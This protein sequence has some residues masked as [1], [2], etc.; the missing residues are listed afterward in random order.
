MFGF[1]FIDFIIIFFQWAKLRYC[2]D[3]FDNQITTVQNIVELEIGDY[4]ITQK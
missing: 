2:I 3:S 4:I 1:R